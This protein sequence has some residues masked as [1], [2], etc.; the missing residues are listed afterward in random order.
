MKKISILTLTILSIVQFNSYAIYFDFAR[1][2]IRKDAIA[3]LNEIVKVMNENP[4]MV[5]ELGSHTDCRGTEKFNQK[6]S[7]ERAKASAD[8][9]K[10]R[11][12]KPSR[13]SS[14]GYGETKLVNIC[15]CGYKDDTKCSETQHQNN[16]RTEFIVVK[17]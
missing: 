8:Y 4:T 14:K 3:D 12:S 6:L 1:Y 10:A 17:E 13:I 2:N 5:I 15:D 7:N 9:I 11:I 16:R